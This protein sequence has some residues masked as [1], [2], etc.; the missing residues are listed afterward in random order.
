MISPLDSIAQPDKLSLGLVFPI[1]SYSGSVPKMEGQEE[2][3]QMAEAIGIK[4]LWFRDV[5]LHDPTFGDAGQMYDPWVYMAHIMNHTSTIMLATGS[6]ILP[7]R[8]PIHTLKSIN[9]LQNLSKGRIIAGIASGDRPIE[10]PAFGKNIEIKSDLFRESFRYLKALNAPFPKHKS[11][12][13]GFLDGNVDLLPKSEIKTPLLVTGHSGQSLDWIAEHSDGWLYYPRNMTFLK[14]SMEDWQQSLK[15]MGQPWKPYMQSLYI[16]LVE[17]KGVGP[18]P[19]HLGFKSGSEYLLFYLKQIR[20]VGVNHVIIN[21]KFSSL[22][23]A[24]TMR[25]LKKEILAGLE[26]GT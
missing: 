25:I 24:Q 23:V 13:F 11:E 18:S 4:A 10:F 2:L 6:V 3:A 14:Y 26:S 19:I 9:S 17:D 21:L 15:N 8:H 22:P 7:L 5:P 1:E 20:K 16:D 12:I